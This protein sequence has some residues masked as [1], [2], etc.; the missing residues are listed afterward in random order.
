M[1]V[2]HRAAALSLAVV[3][4]VAALIGTPAQAVNVTVGGTTYDVQFNDTGTTGTSFSADS[5]LIQASPW[6]GDATLAEDFATAYGAQVARDYPFDLDFSSGSF[7]YL[8]FAYTTDGTSN[9]LR[10]LAEDGS[11]GS[12]P[13]LPNSN[14][15]SNAFYAFAAPSAVPEIDGNA[16]AQAG[17][18]LLALFLVLRGRRQGMA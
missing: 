12:F 14:A 13:P 7:D 9:N 1:I 15:F 4:L 5:A 8:F 16:L 3:T 6:W 11:V 17:L 18:I 10:F 2:F